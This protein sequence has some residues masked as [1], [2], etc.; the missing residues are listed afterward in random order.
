MQLCVFFQVCCVEERASHIEIFFS[1]PNEDCNCVEVGPTHRDNF[2]LTS[3]YISSLQ[4]F[5]PTKLRLRSASLRFRE[6][7]TFA[8]GR[9]KT[10]NRR[11]MKHGRFL[12]RGGNG[13]ASKIQGSRPKEDKVLA[14]QSKLK[15]EGEGRHQPQGPLSAAFRCKI[16][17]CCFLS[18]VLIG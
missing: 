14:T 1:E 16:I 8:P 9:P 13:D 12:R 5:S 17:C 7:L 3:F 10:P 6:L 11:G 18:F 2:K 4:H 15:I